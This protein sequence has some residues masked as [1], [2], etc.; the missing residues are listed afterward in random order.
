MTQST[1]FV[2]VRNR[3]ASGNLFV[4]VDGVAPVA[5]A[6][7]NYIVTASGTTLISTRR[8]DLSSSIVVR[9]ISDTA[10]LVYSITMR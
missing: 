9:L 1:D 7:E 4:R 8:A 2:E 10:S 3:N 5:L 6:K